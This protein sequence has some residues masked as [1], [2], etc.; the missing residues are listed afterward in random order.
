M[1]AG[2]NLWILKPTGYNRG[3]GIHVFSSLS[4]LENLIIEYCKGVE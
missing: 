3:V 2:K 1:N 4:E